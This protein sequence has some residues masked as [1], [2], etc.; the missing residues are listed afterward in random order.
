FHVTGV[1]TCAL[2]IYRPARAEGPDANGRRASPRSLRHQFLTVAGDG[3]RLAALHNKCRAI[4][5]RAGCPRRPIRPNRLNWA[6]AA[7]APRD[8]K[9]VV[10]GQSEAT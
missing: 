2:P 4:P 6:S 9:S 10:E 3:V 7:A 5:E 1:Q 8:R